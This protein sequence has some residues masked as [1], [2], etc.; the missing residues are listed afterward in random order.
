[1]AYTACVQEIAQNIAGDCSKPNVGGYTGQAVLIPWSATP[2]IVQDAKNPRRITSIELKE[3]TKVCVVD[4]VGVDPFSGS[5]TTSNGDSG[6]V[7]YTK[8]FAFRIPLRGADV[9][10]KVV[11]AL[12]QSPEGFIAVLPKAAKV[13]DGGFEVVGFLQPLKTTAD[14]IS[15]TETENGGAILATMTC[16]EPWFELDLVGNTYA[17]AKTLFDKLLKEAF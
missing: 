11:E 5:S 6:V 17:E 7:Q 4:N 12:V 14:G 16:T 8:T 1:M 3:N 9:S 15:R 10:M 2:N 13:A